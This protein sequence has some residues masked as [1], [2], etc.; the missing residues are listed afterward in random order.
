MKLE[1]LF[2]SFLYYTKGERD[3]SLVTK[4]NRTQGNILLTFTQG[5]SSGRDAQVKYGVRRGVVTSLV[6]YPSVP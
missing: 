1:G 4:A 2:R 6:I 3:F 5:K